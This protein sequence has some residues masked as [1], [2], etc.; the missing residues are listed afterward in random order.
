MKREHIWAHHEWDATINWKVMEGGYADLQSVRPGEEITF[1]ISN[2]RSYYEILIFREGATRELVKT[3][4]GLR[5][6]LQER[7]FPRMLTFA[8]PAGRLRPRRR[9]MSCIRC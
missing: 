5:G 1:H 3:I 6:T 8:P 4:E 7:P 2:S 9:G